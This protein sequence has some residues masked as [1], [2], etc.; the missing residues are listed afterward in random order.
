MHPYNPAYFE[1]LFRDS[2]DPWSFTSRWYERRKRALTLACLP[3]ETFSVGYEPGCANGVL[4]A[5]LAARCHRLLVSDGADK[6]VALAR[7]RL[8]DHA[9]VEVVK[10]WLPEQWP[11]EKFDLIVLSEFLFYLQ[12]PSLESIAQKV[13]ASI[14]PG[15]TIL[16]CH[17]RHPV[18]DSVVSGDQAHDRL[19]ELFQMPTICQVRE[20]D[21]RFDVW[22]TAPSVAQR[23]GI[24][25]GLPNT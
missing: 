18:P 17:W 25:N 10:A 7:A 14:M 13:L 16:A 6:A 9:N 11:H 5:D 1:K 22:S 4:S 3:M 8:R 23:E 2:D 15:G 12:P 21:L 20:P 19:D 24:L